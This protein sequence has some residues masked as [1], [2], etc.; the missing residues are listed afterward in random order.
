MNDPFSMENE[1][2]EHNAI[3]NKSSKTKFPFNLNYQASD[4]STEGSPFS[5]MYKYTVSY[6][7]L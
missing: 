7:P 1:K 3:S 4:T 6:K 5:T 2:Y